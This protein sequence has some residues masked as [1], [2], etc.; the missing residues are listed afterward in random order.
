MVLYR[1]LAATDVSGDVLAGVTGE[2]HF[3]DLSVPQRELGDL[4][5]GVA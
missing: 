5:R 1:A 3:Q 2:H 4:L